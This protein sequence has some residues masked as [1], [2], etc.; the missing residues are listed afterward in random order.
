LKANPAVLFKVDNQGDP[1]SRVFF[2]NDGRMFAT[3]GQS[4]LRLWDAGT[5]SA[6]KFLLRAKQG[7]FEDIQFSADGKK[8]AVAVGGD[9]VG[10]VDVAS[11]KTDRGIVVPKEIGVP[12]DANASVDRVA[13]S[14]DGRFLASARGSVAYVW[15][16]KT[17]KEL[18]RLKPKLVGENRYAEGHAGTILALRFTPNG[19][20][21]LT[22]GTD[23]SVRMWDLETGKH[24]RCYGEEDGPWYWQ[25]DISPDGQKLVVLTDAGVKQWNAFSGKKGIDIP[26]GSSEDPVNSVALSPDSKTIVT[27]AA[28][29]AARLWDLST[30]KLVGVMLH[31]QEVA[32]AA[33]NPKQ[34]GRVVTAT[35]SEAWM[36]DAKHKNVALAAQEEL[37]KSK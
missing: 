30:G 11:M 24:L 21:L 3:Q 35:G 9:H 8:L 36:W 29:Y 6:L 12:G 22:S 14:A 20:A 23:S 7:I 10:I 37:R 33:F 17:G 13:Y 15:D 26:M 32:W 28:D 16:A 4:T 19:Q 5:G 1:V 25:V 2:S 27:A 31:P 34:P 18:L